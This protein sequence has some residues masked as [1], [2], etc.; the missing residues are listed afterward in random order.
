MFTHPAPE[1]SAPGRRVVRAAA[2][3]LPV[4]GDL[5]LGGKYRI[6]EVLG[7]GGMGV[8]MGAEHITLGRKVAFKFLAPS[9]ASDAARFV[10]EARAAALID[11]EHVARVNDVGVLESGAAYMLMERLYGENVG[12]YV[13]RVGPRPIGEAVYCVLQAC[14]AIAAAH[15]AGIIHRDIKPSN[16]FLSLRDDQTCAIKVLDFGISKL[17]GSEAGD[18]VSLTRSGAILGSPR[19]MSPEQVRNPKRVDQRTDI[20]GLGLVLHELLTGTPVYG[21]DTFPALCMAIVG[22]QPTALREQRPDAPA[23]LEAVLLRCAQKNPA[24][25]FSSVI[26]L[27]VA[28]APFAPAEAAPIVARIIRRAGPDFVVP[29]PVDLAVAAQPAGDTANGVSRPLSASEVPTQATSK[30]RRQVPAV[31]LFLASTLTFVCGAAFAYRAGEV[32]LRARSSAATALVAAYSPPAAPPVVSVY[33]LP[34]DATS[35]PP[36]LVVPIQAPTEDLA[37]APV[38]TPANSADAANEAAAPRAVQATLPAKKQHQGASH[39]E[40]DDEIKNAV[41][42]N[43]Y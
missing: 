10:R 1:S 28:L 34:V 24:H 35:A 29:T 19:Y 14:D 42:L 2:P 43:R 8:V 27:A 25:R 36:P 32:A 9:N 31:G 17:A 38:P 16:L 41:L 40:P 22:N 11:S 30:G 37:Q 26:E 13:R 7:T 15:A 23:E 3:K 21:G 5:V 6:D 33:D 12:A 18:E 4:L 39:A 20:W